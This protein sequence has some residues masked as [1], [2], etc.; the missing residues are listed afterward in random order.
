MRSQPAD[1]AAALRFLPSCWPAAWHVPAGDSPASACFPSGL[2]ETA[3]AGLGAQQAQQQ[4]LSERSPSLQETVSTASRASEVSASGHLESVEAALV[5]AA[6]Y[7]CTY[8]TAFAQSRMLTAVHGQW[9][10][11][12]LTA[13][14]Q[15]IRLAA[16]APALCSAYC[17]HLTLSD[18]CG[19]PLPACH[20]SR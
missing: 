13:S 9:C 12:V 20:V 2:Q 7:L 8:S 1:K 6:G 4:A 16:G 10:L 5:R 11:P 3:A 17:A 14:S 19:W 18:A 15:L